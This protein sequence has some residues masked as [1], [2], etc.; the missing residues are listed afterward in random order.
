MDFFKTIWK[1]KR[2][3]WQLGKNDF[4]N[5]F[6]ATSLGAIWGFLQPFVFLITY[7]IVLQYI[8][9]AKSSGDLP[10]A[11]WYLPAMAI[12][13][14]INDSVS[15]VTN[16]I[17]DYSYLVKKVLF[18]VDVI[19]AIALISSSIV[20]IFVIFVATAISLIYGFIPNFLLMG[21]YVFAAFCFIL[22]FT[23]LTSAITALVPDFGQ[24]LTIVMQILFWFSP[25]I[26][27]L[28]FIE[29]MAGGAVL[30]LAKC[31]PFSYIIVGFRQAFVGGGSILTD[32]NG[33]YSVIFWI[34]TILMFIWSNHI[35]KKCK[36][37]FADVL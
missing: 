36:K 32:T 7:A 19:P 37:D 16:S 12:W 33:I 24:L 34:L 18:P 27:D 4:K 15:N 28:S 8:L 1:N 26:W 20:S 21:Y 30:K 17:R 5:K 13:Q 3:V 23:R 25:I 31:M 9:K 2:L 14:F 11:V 35:F 6:A 22:G 29:G 10:F